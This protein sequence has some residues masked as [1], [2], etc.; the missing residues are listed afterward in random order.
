MRTLDPAGF[1]LGAFHSQPHYSVPGAYRGELLAPPQVPFTAPVADSKA[2]A[3]SVRDV[4]L[5]SYL[6]YHSNVCLMT[7]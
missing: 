6:H 3:N 1:L 2:N 7:I 4:L 5:M